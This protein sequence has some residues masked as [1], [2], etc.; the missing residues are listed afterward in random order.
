MHAHYSMQKYAPIGASEERARMCKALLTTA[1]SEPV[2]QFLHSAIRQN[3]TNQIR[4][5]GL[6]DR[7][8]VCLLF[9]S[10]KMFRLS[11]PS[12]ANH[13][14]VAVVLSTVFF[15]PDLHRA[16]PQRSQVSHCRV[17]LSV[18]GGNR[19]CAVA[20]ALQ[21]KLAGHFSLWLR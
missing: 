2:Y 10:A 18:I 20:L 14:T 16:M 13:A 8:S 7:Y 3:V 17:Q 6:P 21:M 11:L 1:L 15:S 12:N 4:K 19:C 5:W 9:S